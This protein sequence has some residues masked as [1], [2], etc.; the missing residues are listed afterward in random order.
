MAKTAN[1]IAHLNKRW[2]HAVLKMVCVS[3]LVFSF[4]L[5][6]N[7][8]T[9]ETATNETV[10][11]ETAV[12]AR[13]GE[14]VAQ[15][16]QMHGNT[17]AQESTNNEVT[18]EAV[19]RTRETRA[20]VA[21]SSNNI[22]DVPSVTG[23]WKLEAGGWRFYNKSG[24]MQKGF[25][26]I[27]GKKYYFGPNDGLMKVGWQKVGRYYYYLGVAGDGS[28][29]TGWHKVSGLWYYFQ[30]NGVMSYGMADVGSSVYYFGSSSDGAMKTG[31]QTIYDL[32]YY[33]G[34]ANDGAMKKG[35]QYVSGNWYYFDE[36]GYMY[37]GRQ[38]IGGKNYYFGTANDGAMK[39]GWQKV[40]SDW[41]YLNGSGDGSAKTG[42]NSL[43]GNWYYFDNNGLMKTGWQTIAGSVY[44]LGVTNDGS[45]KTGW[46]KEG[47]NWYY[48]DGTGAAQKGW[49]Q[50]GGYWYYLESNYALVRDTIKNI[51]GRNYVFNADGAMMTKSFTFKGRKYIADE[52]G[53]VISVNESSNVIDYGMQFLGENGNRFNDWYYNGNTK[54][55]S[56][57]W[58]NTFVSYVLYN[59]GINF[60]KT[61]YVP[62][63]EQWMHSNYK[64]VDYK[65]AKAGDV[66]VFCWS[67]QGHNSGSG[68]R[69]HIG[70]LISRNADGTFTTLEGN[71]SN[72]K[73]AIRTRYSKNIRNIFSPR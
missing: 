73:V 1:N 69:D 42:W 3:M 55:R 49:Q 38:A 32:Y 56:W 61:A 37:S 15:A 48:S 64:L 36:T 28:A 53:V 31:W 45:M 51:A 46:F 21:T 60:K 19:D 25:C 5:V 58:C 68:N 62:N 14:S 52:S 8:S 17:D 22:A 24:V 50:I 71:T 33:F 34:G 40:G 59:C 43:G 18:T 57:A 39:A 27:D 47:D 7:A 13:Q 12:E 63:A 72:G 70:F 11:N 67:G 2:H 29:K 9:E 44:Y 65:D 20:A 26:Y 30:V 16:D 6:A 66:I 54:Y 10:T 41:M 23:T 4:C 35:W